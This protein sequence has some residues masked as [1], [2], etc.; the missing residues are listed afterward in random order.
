MLS[1]TFIFAQKTKTESM[2]DLFLLLVPLSGYTQTF[3]KD[4][5]EGTKELSLSILS[6]LG[7]TYLLKYSV[8]KERP[9]N[10]DNLSFPSGHTSISFSASTFIYKRYGVKYAI[11][12]YLASIYV[13]YSRVYAK[14]H[15][16]LDVISGGVVGII[17]SLYFTSSFK[18][19]QVQPLTKNGCS[20]FLLKYKW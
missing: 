3:I 4:D 14:Q 18:G 15:D 16:N 7:S 5:C 17:S 20:G 10:K 2:G 6:T 13:G 9:N 11:L 12:P 8:K 19:I 1:C